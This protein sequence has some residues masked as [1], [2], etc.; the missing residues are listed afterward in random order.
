M[1]KVYKVKAIKIYEIDVIA[2]SEEEAWDYADEEPITEWEGK[3]F[4][5]ESAE[6]VSNNA[7]D[8]FGPDTNEERMGWV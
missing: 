6:C 3:D 8:Y 7:N 2:D 1:R 4:I 5:I